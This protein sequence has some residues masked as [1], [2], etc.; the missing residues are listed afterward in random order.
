MFFEDRVYRVSD[1]GSAGVLAE[2][3]D[4][5]D[6][7]ICTAFRLGSLMLV[8]DSPDDYIPGRDGGSTGQVYAVVRDGR[9]VERLAVSGVGLERLRETISEIAARRRGADLGPAQIDTGHQDGFS[10]PGCWW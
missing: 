2:S 9:L 8:N 3:L 4:C 6:W 1:V 5:V 10:C 7:P